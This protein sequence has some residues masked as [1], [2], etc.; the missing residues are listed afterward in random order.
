MPEE[1][2]M[3]VNQ[4]SPLTPDQRAE[5]ARP[6]EDAPPAHHRPT[7]EA[8]GP[9]AEHAPAKATETETDAHPNLDDEPAKPLLPPKTPNK[10]PEKP[11]PKKATAKKG[12]KK[13]KK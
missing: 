10:E 13:G 4:D 1:K 8:D 11:A 3:P 2:K 6:I 7:V 9:K 5:I 12:T